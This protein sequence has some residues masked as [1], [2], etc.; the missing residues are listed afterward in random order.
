M[1]ALDARGVQLSI[2][3]SSCKWEVG[4]DVFVVASLILRIAVLDV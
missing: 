4:G 1:A 3:R 2:H